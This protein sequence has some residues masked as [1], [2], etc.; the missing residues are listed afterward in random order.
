[1][2]FLGAR[3][4]GHQIIESKRERIDLLIQRLSSWTSEVKEVTH[5]DWTK[6][7]VHAEDAEQKVQRLE[8]LAFVGQ[9]NDADL[10]REA[11]ILDKDAKLSQGFQELMDAVREGL[12]P[13]R[14][15]RVSSFEEPEVRPASDGESWEKSASFPGLS[16]TVG[17]YYR[18]IGRL[19]GELEV[20]DLRVVSQSHT[21][22]KR[23]YRERRESLNNELTIMSRNWSDGWAASRVPF[24]PPSGKS[25]L[26]LAEVLGKPLFAR[27]KGPL[28]GNLWDMT[29]VSLSR[30]RQAPSCRALPAYTVGARHSFRLDCY[31]YS[32]QAQGMGA[33]LQLV[34]GLVYQSPD[35]NLTSSDLPTEVDFLFP[36][37][38]AVGGSNFR[39]EVMTVLAANASRKFS[40][41][42][43]GTGDGNSTA[44]GFLIQKGQES[45]RVTASEIPLSK[46]PGA[47]LVK[48]VRV[49]SL[50]A[51]VLPP[52]LVPTPK[53][54]PAPAPKRLPVS[55]PKPILVPS[56]SPLP[57]P[58]PLPILGPTPKPLRPSIP[59][60]PCTSD[61]R[62]T[63]RGVG[64][65]VTLDIVIVGENNDIT[66]K[67]TSGPAHYGHREIPDYSTEG[68]KHVFLVKR[69]TGVVITVEGK[70]NTI[71]LPSSKT[72]RCRDLGT[73]NLIFPG[74]SSCPKPL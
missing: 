31:Y 45:M 36:R 4:I 57:A 62:P 5:Y 55:L 38:S 49:F 60:T 39:R 51:S 66:L 35:Q 69:D 3:V 52:P 68:C 21:D 19:L 26:P 33:E 22:L 18:E 2:V 34:V 54:A 6:M 71:R 25:P 16:A 12:D 53:P 32:A 37:P 8:S 28:V 67:E 7:D 14:V 59:M 17:R 61:P 41:R 47:L 48:V 73:G 63:L 11:V 42:V 15:P 29:S 43:D 74:R 56:P 20:T 46:Q 24:R 72:I 64:E 44:D 10:W 9:I 13:K 1:L 40:E 27:K 70:Y 50:P 30:V 23:H 65:G 58:S